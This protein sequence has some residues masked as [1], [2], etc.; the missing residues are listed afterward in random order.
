M[1]DQS[2]DEGG[3]SVNSVGNENKSAEG[4]RNP[5]HLLIR[6]KHNNLIKMI[7]NDA[8]TKASLREAKRIAPSATPRNILKQDIEPMNVD[9][10]EQDQ[11]PEVEQQTRT[12]NVSEPSVDLD[13]TPQPQ[14][15]ALGQER[16]SSKVMCE[17]SEEVNEERL[18]TV[19]EESKHCSSIDDNQNIH[20]HPVRVLSVAV[21]TMTPRKTKPSVPIQQAQASIRRAIEE[22]EE[23]LMDDDDIVAGRYFFKLQMCPKTDHQAY[24]YQAK[25]LDSVIQED[26]QEITESFIMPSPGL[27]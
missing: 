8:P 20:Y 4:K 11:N 2:S 14:Q 1:V 9:Q 16:Q 10:L 7:N 13:R 25:I 24:L 6:K 21:K 27:R 3:V 19:F 22:I 26:S 15:L 17:S 12:V 5:Q 23:Q 18:Y